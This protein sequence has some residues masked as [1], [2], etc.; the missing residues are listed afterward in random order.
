VSAQLSAPLRW[1]TPPRNQGQ[2]VTVSYACTPEGV[3]ER[4]YDASDGSHVVR[5]ARWSARLERWAESSGP[6]NSDPPSAR[7]RRVS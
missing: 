4:T 7:W 1:V 3:W 5:F 2:I 6:Q